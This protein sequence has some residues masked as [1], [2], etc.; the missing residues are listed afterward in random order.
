MGSMNAFLHTGGDAPRVWLAV[1]LGLRL[2]VAVFFVLLAYK[3]LSDD[4]QMVADFQRWGYP[5][6]F[7]RMTS[8]LQI[9]GAV[10]LVPTATCFLGGAI[11]AG[12]LVGALATHLM[13]D[14][15]PASVSPAVFLVLVVATTA[16]FRPQLLQ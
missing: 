16:W 4:P 2:L 3:N 1:G 14:P 11:L 5:V 12:I 7:R 8:V 13:F 15:L 10:L 9:V 6:W